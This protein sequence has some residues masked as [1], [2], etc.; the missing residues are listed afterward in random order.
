MKLLIITAIQSF[1]SDIKMMLQQAE[2]KKYSYR[3]VTGF[4]N[5][6]EQFIADNWFASESNETESVLFYSFV[7]KETADKVFHLANEFNGRQESPSQ[8]HVVI[9]NIEKSNHPTLHIV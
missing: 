5:D 2:V 6:P 8:V 1:E 7:K 3:E 9:L 4:K